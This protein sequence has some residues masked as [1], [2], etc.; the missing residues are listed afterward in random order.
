MNEIHQYFIYDKRIALSVLDTTQMVQEGVKIHG[1]TGKKAELFGCLLTFCA[2][3]GSTLKNANG[4]V[5]VLVK[6]PVS[7]SITVSC[8]S[9]LHVRGCVDW[10][11]EVT[12]RDGTITVISDDGYAR[13]FVGTCYMSHEDISHNIEEYYRQSAQVVTFVRVGCKVENDA[14]V[15]AGGTVASCLPDTPFAVMEDCRQNL[16]C[17]RDICGAIMNVGAKNIAQS[18][19]DC[20][21][22]QSVTPQ[23]RCNCSRHKI[24]AVLQTLGKQEVKDII[25]QQGCV[26]VHC[27]YCNTD[28]QFY[29]SDVDEIFT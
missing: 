11:G 7:G 4:S 20:E 21:Y 28:Y 19:P 17:F 29:D 23:Y 1:L 9:S 10:E 8:D 22:L 16:K 3:L 6:S 25:A 18:M 26:S 5:S 24:S 12:L 2:Y 15:C 27:H 14:C 13:P